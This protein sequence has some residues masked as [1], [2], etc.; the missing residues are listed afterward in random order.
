MNK[1]LESVKPSVSQIAL[2]EKVEQAQAIGAKYERTFVS[3][4]F[5]TILEKEL[6][7]VSIP[8]KSAK[9]LKPV[10]GHKILVFNDE[11][12]DKLTMIDVKDHFVHG[13]FTIRKADGQVRPSVVRH[14]CVK[15]SSLG[16]EIAA[17]V[18]VK[19]KKCLL[20]GDITIIIDIIELLPGN[21][22]TKQSLCLGGNVTGKTG[23]IIIPGTDRCIRID[24]VKVRHRRKAD[25]KKT[26]LNIQSSGERTH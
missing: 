6:V 19:Q 5:K 22:Q 3:S 24:E 17:N 4:I 9:Y 20:T 12:L 15:E 11:K 18:V 8:G 7:L 14:F 2:T 23:E 21:Y 10:K 13:D 16:K 1:S 25:R 26:S